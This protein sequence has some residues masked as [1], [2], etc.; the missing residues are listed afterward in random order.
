M[1]RFK[2]QGQA[3]RFLYCHGVINNMCRL[4]RHLMAAKHYR[5]FRDRSFSE[6]AQVTCVENLS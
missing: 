5:T 4:G 1:R 6:W 2:L 3:Q